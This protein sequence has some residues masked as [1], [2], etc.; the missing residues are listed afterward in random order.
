M[1]V[2]FTLGVF[3]IS[4]SLSAAL[5]RQRIPIEAARKVDG[6]LNLSTAILAFCGNNMVL[7]KPSLDSMRH[8]DSVWIRIYENSKKSSIVV[9][10]L[11]VVVPTLGHY[12]AGNWPRGLFFVIRILAGVKIQVTGIDRRN[13][14]TEAIGAVIAFGSYLWIVIDS[15]FEV[16]RYNENLYDKLVR[17]QSQTINVVPVNN[18][19]RL[20]FS[21]SF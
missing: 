18:N 17:R 1:R 15:Y 5:A 21:F 13:K 10:L 6:E 14:T 9:P 12:Y 16:E 8:A 3:I 2:S 4:L 7:Q 19:V 11:S 20:Q